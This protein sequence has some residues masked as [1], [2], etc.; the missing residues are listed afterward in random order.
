MTLDLDP[1][2]HFK[3]IYFECASMVIKW[4]VE[5]TTLL[6]TKI[7]KWLT[8]KDQNYLLSNLDDP[9]EELV[10]E[11]YAN[12]I[13]GGE[14][15]RCWVRGKEFTIMPSY[16]ALILNINRPMFAKPLVYDQ[17]ESD[18]EIFR[19]AFGENLDVSSNGKSISLSSLSLELKLLTKIIFHNLY[20]FSS[21]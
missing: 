5:L 20:P 1:I 18:L 15:L 3:C 13:F 9:Y 14:E 11:F 16:L 12:A 19:D 2:P 10:K 17:M 6:D 8:S 21:T 7:P 4:V